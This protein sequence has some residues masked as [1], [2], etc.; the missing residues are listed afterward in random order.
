MME[1]ELKLFGAFREFEPSGSVRLI[2]PSD[3]DV[4]ALRQAL[5]HY[6]Q[7]NWGAAYKPG[8]LK[9]SAF[10]NDAELLRD[11]SRVADQKGLAL[12]P[13]VSGG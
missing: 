12:L 13:P 9:V 5:D 11:H 8:L 6:A 7:Q 3:A 1:I 2:V 10:S 4:A